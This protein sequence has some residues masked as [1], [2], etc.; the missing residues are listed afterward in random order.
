MALKAES[1]ERR[2]VV[3]HTGLTDRL[4]DICELPNVTAANDA[5]GSLVAHLD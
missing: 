1:P 3:L 5:A 4:N 2:S